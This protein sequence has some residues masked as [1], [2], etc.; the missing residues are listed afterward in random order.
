MCIMMLYPYMITMVQSIIIIVATIG[1]QSVNYSIIEGEL[2]DV[3][4]VE[5]LSGKLGREVQVILN[6]GRGTHTGICIHYSHKERPRLAL[7]LLAQTGV[8][9]KSAQCMHARHSHAYIIICMRTS[10]S[11]KVCA[12]Q[13]RTAHVI[14][15]YVHD[16][17]P[18]M[19]SLYERCKAA[20]WS[21][22]LAESHFVEPLAL[23]GVTPCSC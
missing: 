5:V 21:V 22:L 12:R 7:L 6:T 23:Y 15:V 16:Y 8:T 2:N 3:V 20:R 1:F 10:R 19:R 4:T 18:I 11:Q 14:R 13:R 17:M 9:V